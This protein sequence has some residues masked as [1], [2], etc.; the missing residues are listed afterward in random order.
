MSRSPK[1]E[2]ASPAREQNKFKRNKQS[3]SSQLP[4]LK[5]SSFDGNP[6]EWTE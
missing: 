3:N 6:L 1:G 5:L 4:K 2:R